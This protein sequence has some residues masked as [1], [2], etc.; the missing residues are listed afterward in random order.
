VPKEVLKRMKDVE[1][2]DRRP[3]PKDIMTPAAAALKE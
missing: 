2:K 1:E 3:N